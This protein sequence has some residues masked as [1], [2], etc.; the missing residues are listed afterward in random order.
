MLTPILLLIQVFSIKL[1]ALYVDKLITLVVGLYLF[2]KF[3]N[4]KLIP[5]VTGLLLVVTIYSYNILI[6]NQLQYKY[7]VAY[8]NVLANFYIGYILGL[9]ATIKIVKLSFS[10]LI[11]L[12]FIFVYVNYFRIDL[13]EPY[14]REM[15]SNQRSLIAY[16]RFF[17]PFF[18][19]P[20]MAS[21]LALLLIF[22]ISFFNSWGF[23]VSSFLIVGLL[24]LILLTGSDSTPIAL[25]MSFMTLMFFKRPILFLSSIIGLIGLI[26]FFVIN[27]DYDYQFIFEDRHF[28]LRKETLEHLLSS[29]LIEFLFGHGLGV[30]GNYISGAYSFSSLLTVLFE[31]GLASF[32]LYMFIFTFPMVSLIKSKLPKN[33]ELY[34]SSFLSIF[35]IFYVNLFYELKTLVVIFLILGLYSGILNSRNSLC[36]R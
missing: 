7:I 15:H 4:K 33:N 5:F 32:I 19:S 29:S 31:G 12:A 17:F 24:F 36:Y 6:E 25:I 1:S 14:Y 35:F 3:P 9:T 13:L 20:H 21:F 22:V 2:T 28:I 30:S 18:T 8:F 16:G 11:I 10:L 23:I 34:V 27:I 26:L